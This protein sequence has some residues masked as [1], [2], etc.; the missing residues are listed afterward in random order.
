MGDRQ[1]LYV[2]FVSRHE[3]KHHLESRAVDGMIILKESA[4]CGLELST[5]LIAVV[6]L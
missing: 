3:G 6:N 4:R 5:F 1:G 2:V